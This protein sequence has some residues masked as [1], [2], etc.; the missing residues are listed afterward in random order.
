MNTVSFRSDEIGLGI[1][2]ITSSIGVS[3]VLVKFDLIS[4]E[5]TDATEALH[6]LEALLRLVCDELNLNSEASVVVTEPLG[7]RVL[8]KDV[9]ILPTLLILEVFCVLFLGRVQQNGLGVALDGI[10]KHISVN[11]EVFE[12]HHGL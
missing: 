2:V 12:E 5:T 3:N 8:L 4:Q 10:L 1:E 7:Q 6:E 11:F 9:V